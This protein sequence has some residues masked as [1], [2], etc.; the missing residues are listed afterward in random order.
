MTTN[1]YTGIVGMRQG[2][3]EFPRNVRQVR[4]AIMEEKLGPR[5]GA[6]VD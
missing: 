5:L 4:Q 3:E 2:P 1:H 6:H